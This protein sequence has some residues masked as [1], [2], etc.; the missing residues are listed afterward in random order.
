MSKTTNKWFDPLIPSDIITYGDMCHAF[1][2]L[3]IELRDRNVGDFTEAA[4]YSY[5]LTYQMYLNSMEEIVF[6]RCVDSKLIENPSNYCNRTIVNN[7]NLTL[8][9]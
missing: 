4:I 7:L 6:E 1:K 8:W 3:F 9:T 2:E 5:V